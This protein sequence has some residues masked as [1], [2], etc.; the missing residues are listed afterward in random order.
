[1]KG[2]RWE[3]NGMER[4]YAHLCREVDTEF[5]APAN[6]RG[7]IKYIFTDEIPYVC[8]RCH[9]LLQILLSP[10]EFREEEIDVKIYLVDQD[11]EDVIPP[12]QGKLVL[13]KEQWRQGDPKIYNM[14]ITFENIE[15]PEYDN[16]VFNLI[17]EK[18]QM[19]S[20]PISI[21]TRLGG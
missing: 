17:V 2:Y 19:A 15:F 3:L 4:I 18:N 11:G 20:V 7:I 9:L 14:M 13:N 5:G 10:D 16:Y 6:I 8:N 21:R 1:M 12:S